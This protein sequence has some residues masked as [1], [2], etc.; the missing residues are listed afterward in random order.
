MTLKLDTLTWACVRIQGARVAGWTPGTRYTSEVR[1]YRARWTGRVVWA[2][3]VAA[4]ALAG[5][6]EAL[7]P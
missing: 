2:L 5:F 1:A 4:I 3:V 6:W 7:A